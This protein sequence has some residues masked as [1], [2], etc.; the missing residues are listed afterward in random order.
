[1]EASVRLTPDSVVGL[2]PD[3]TLRGPPWCPA[4]AGAA[5]TPSS[6][7]S[8]SAAWALPWSQA[9]ANL[10][11]RVAFLRRIDGETW[12]DL[13]DDALLAGLEDWLAPFLAGITRRSHLTRLDLKGALEAQLGAVVR[14]AGASGVEVPVTAMIYHALLPQERLTRKERLRGA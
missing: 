7:A 11:A 6:V 2:K 1:M 8:S 10:R 9:A 14:L 5:S 12:P 3:S 4:S 13:S